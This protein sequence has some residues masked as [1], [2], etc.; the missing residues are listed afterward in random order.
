M[1]MK[2]AYLREQL[3]GGRGHAVPESADDWHLR[4][5]ADGGTLKMLKCTRT[6]AAADSKHLDS[7]TGY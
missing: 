4:G 5:R 3:A 1:Q 2:Q 6:G 7:S